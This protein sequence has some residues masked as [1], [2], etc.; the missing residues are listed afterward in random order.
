MSPGAIVA[1]GRARGL[2]PRSDVGATLLTL[3]DLWGRDA[4]RIHE[5]L[6]AAR[7][8]N[9]R[10]AIV[11]A[12]L[13]RR[14]DT[15]RAVDAEVAFCGRELLV[16]RGRVR[17]DRLAAEAGWSRK[18]LWSRFR[19]QVGL[20][21][22]RAAQLIRFDYAAHRLIAGRSPASVAAESG[23]VDQSHLDR[24]VTTFAGQTPAALAIA[25]FLSVDDVAWVASDHRS[26]DWT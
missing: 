2:W 12:A 20:N 14:H 5:Q 25:P 10:F 18:R 26:R 11:E 15:G 17:I 7:S 19:A 3:D 24:D 22:K 21:P 4:L 6:R 16:N 1:D 23:Y 13:A 9:D 8:W